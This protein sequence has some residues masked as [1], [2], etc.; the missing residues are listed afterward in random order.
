MTDKKPDHR[1]VPLDKETARFKCGHSGPARYG[2]VIFGKR[3]DLKPEVLRGRDRCG[4]CLLD[5]IT[6]GA[7]QCGQCGDP[8]FKGAD[9]VIFE[10]KIC[11]LKT[12]CSPG[13]LGCEVGVWDGRQFVDGILAGTVVCL[14]RR[15]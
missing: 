12:S 7:T 6:E 11:C 1:V 3:F 13:P 2:H 9:C 5:A 15:G 4:Q 8:I 14:P 10:G